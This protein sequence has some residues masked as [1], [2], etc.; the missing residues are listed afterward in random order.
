MAVACAQITR[1]RAQARDLAHEGALLV[2]VTRRAALGQKQ[3]QIGGF[4]GKVIRA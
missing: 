3:A 1:K 4:D 2:D